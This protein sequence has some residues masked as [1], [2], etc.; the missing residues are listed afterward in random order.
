MAI[1]KE[2]LTAV[3][4]VGAILGSIFGGLLG[5]FGAGRTLQKQISR[6]DAHDKAITAQNE[7]IATIQKLFVTEDGEPRL[8]SVTVC[9]GKQAACHV[10]F[11]ERHQT[12]IG[13]M[14]EQG[15]MIGEIYRYILDSKKGE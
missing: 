11:E 14:S 8:I 15:K 7:V 6:I 10:L 9:D 13:I 2:E 1:G 5:V 3:G 4:A 12:V